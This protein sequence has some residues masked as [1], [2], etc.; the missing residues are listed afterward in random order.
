MTVMNSMETNPAPPAPHGGELCNLLVAA[1]L[2]EDLKTE[3]ERYISVTLTRRQLCDLELLMNGGFSPLK[4]FMG[5]AAYESVLREMRLPD[6][7]LWPVPIVLDISAAV[8]Q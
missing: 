3:S 8:E 4:G 5:R 1:D 6:G 7:Q 2:A